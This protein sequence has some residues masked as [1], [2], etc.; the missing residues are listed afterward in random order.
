MIFLFFN[1]IVL[2]QSTL[3][4]NLS[5]GD[6]FIIKQ[7]ANQLITQEIEGTTHEIT[8]T[9]GGVM[10]FRVRAENENTYDIDV[11]FK[12][13]NLKMMSS[14]QGELLN[15]SAKDYEENDIQSKIFNSMLN[16][17][18][19][20]TLARTGDILEV[21]GGDSLVS[22]MASA[23]GVEDEYSL[24][25]MKKSLEKEF[26]SEALSN[27]YKQFTFLYP[28]SSVEVGDSWNNEYTGKMQAQ[29]TWT[30]KEIS[31]AS[32]DIEG[33]A[34]VVM[35]VIEPASTMK[36][37]GTQDSSVITDISS[38]FARKM[39]VTGLVEGF[40]TMSQMGDQEIPTKIKST[41]IYELIED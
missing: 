4:Y 29:N 12:D 2:G 5:V 35:E 37:N 15:V 26:G 19:K 33:N 7:D 32:A 41:I 18:V 38:G 24:D 20:V 11:V 36:L 13:L 6:V 21:N 27:S 22:K 28:T 1:S 10:E 40:T 14:S 17:P 30:L 3:Q 23:S 31:E 9:L 8:N 16:V 39:T 25:M 34:L